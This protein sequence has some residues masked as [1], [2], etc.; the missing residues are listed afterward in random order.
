MKCV[1]CGA[2]VVNNVC[3]YCGTHYDNDN[4]GSFSV[5]FRD[6]DSKGT[7]R[8]GDKEYKVYID[9]VKG[10]MASGSTPC[11]DIA[12]RI[13]MIPNRM[14]HTFVLKEW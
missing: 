13:I 14:M 2:D 4:G 5:K 1:N 12:G 7:L 9:E 11:R 10:E 6:P 3:E 8:I